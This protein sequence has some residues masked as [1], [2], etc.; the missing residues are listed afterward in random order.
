MDI[1]FVLSR[2]VYNDKIGR[3][4]MRKAYLVKAIIVLILSVLAILSYV[5]MSANEI[6]KLALYEYYGFLKTFDFVLSLNINTILFLPFIPVYFIHS[7]LKKFV[8]ATALSLLLLISFSGWLYILLIIG[9]SDQFMR[10]QRNEVYRVLLIQIVV[11]LLLTIVGQVPFDTSLVLVVG[12]YVLMLK[13]S[14]MND[15]VLTICLINTGVVH[16]ESW[17]LFPILSIAI[18]KELIVN[19]RNDYMRFI[20]WSFLISSLRIEWTA[21]A[22]MVMTIVSDQFEISITEKLKN[23]IS[24]VFISICI[25]ILEIPLEMKIFLTGGLLS[26]LFEKKSEVAYGY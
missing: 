23:T 8:I 9:I 12:L 21:L 20:F 17:V 5:Y 18:L 22:F 15:F 6:S 26:Y 13:R 1:D 4:Y 7:D 25:V 19:R 2:I 11:L 24:I 3:E 10:E 14:L 16:V